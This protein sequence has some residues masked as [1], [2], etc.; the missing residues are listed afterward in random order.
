MHTLGRTDADASSVRLD[1]WERA[2]VERAALHRLARRVG[3]SPTDA[4]DC[5]QEAILSVVPRTDVDDARLGG[6]LAVAV[7]RRAIDM[8]RRTD[9]ARR[10]SRRLDVVGRVEAE[11]VDVALCD[12]A[13]AE[14][15][16]TLLH[17]LPPF[18]RDVLVARAEGRPWKEIARDFET[19][20]TAV[21]SAVARARAAMRFAIA[22]TFGIGIALVRRW[23]QP[24]P[25]V[26]A[27]TATLIIVA[28]V[29]SMLHPRAE[30]GDSARPRPEPTAPATLHAGAGSPVT[31]AARSDDGRRADLAPPEVDTTAPPTAPAQPPPRARDGYGPLPAAEPPMSVSVPILNRV[32]S[33]VDDCTSGLRISGMA[34]DAPVPDP[35]RLANPC[36]TGRE[37]RG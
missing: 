12:R 4:D 21:E 36:N 24:A 26:A 6:L 5:V 33:E 17:Q 13:E 9:A 10:A 11:A 1:R 20:V 32:S 8:Y 3:L 18:Q 37:Y 29:A 27:G 22:S 15:S 35:D 16:A 2:E 28:A 7:K 30:V 19:S 25:T 23:R 34:T 14:W 31:G